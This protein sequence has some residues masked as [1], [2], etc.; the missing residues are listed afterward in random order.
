MARKKQRKNDEGARPWMV[1][2]CET[3]SFDGAPV[4]PFIWGWKTS[5]GD[6]GITWNTWE[7]V[8]ILKEF[9]G[10]ALAHNGGKFD[11]V[12]LSK[13]FERGEIKI[14]N[15]RVAEVKIGKA[16]VRDSFLIIPSALGSAGNKG[17]FDY[18]IL[19]RNKKH[20]RKKHRAEI[21]EY[22]IQDCRGLYELVERFYSRFG[23]RLTQAGAALAEWEK[24]GGMVR[25]WGGTHDAHFRQFYFGGRCEAF[26]KGA[27][28]D[29]WEYFDIKSSYP[30]AMQDFHPASHLSDY[31]VHCDIKKI[32]PQSFVRCM[33]ANHGCLPHRGK[34]VTEY[35]HH[36]EPRE[37]FATGWE[38]IAG[39]E[40][41]TIKIFSASIWRPNELETLKPYTDRF[42]AEKL[43]AEKRG[44]KI[45]RTIAKIFQN[46]VSPL[47]A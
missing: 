17:E 9:D 1:F 25:R 32:T 24:M 16:T 3:D 27:L 12:M 45:D 31:F 40:T 46:S 10:I 42:Y 26:Q 18:S 33:A 37:Y 39:L 4:A 38:I 29:G 44:D 36:D 2:D 22:L 11:T 23:Q 34:Y 19:D 21:E 30:N 13:H 43:D 28:G 47:P 14:I 6:E 35:P 15:G 5:E 41:N 8:D 20:L 7:F